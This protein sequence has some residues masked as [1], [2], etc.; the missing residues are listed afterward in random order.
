MTLMVP[1]MVSLFVKTGKVSVSP[2]RPLTATV[3]RGVPCGFENS[4]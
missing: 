4:R 3:G 2:F 1:V